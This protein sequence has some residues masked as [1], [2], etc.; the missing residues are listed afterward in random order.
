MIINLTS[1]DVCQIIES[2]AKNNVTT[3]K[4]GSLFLSFNRPV[5]KPN[6]DT[7]ISDQQIDHIQRAQSKESLEQQ[8]A[9]FRQEQI[10]MAILENPVLAE[11]MIAEEDLA[12]ADDESGLE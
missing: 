4:F 7:A 6:A 3:L 12:D 11:Q 9:D 8:E 1:Q 5:E 2:C 10:A